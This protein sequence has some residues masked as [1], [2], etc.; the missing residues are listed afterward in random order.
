[1]KEIA[2]SLISIE[3]ATEHKNKLLEYERTSEKRTIVI[4]DEM[5]Y[6][7]LSKENWL[8]NEKRQELKDKIDKL[9]ED[10]FEID[11]RFELDFDSRQVVEV[12]IPKIKDLNEEVKK[13]KEETEFK[14]DYEIVD[15][16]EILANEP[17]VRPY[18]V[19]ENDNKNNKKDN[20]KD[21]KKPKSKSNK[22]QKQSDKNLI[23]YNLPNINL[24]RNRLQNSELFDSTDEG[25]ALSI[26]QP[27]AS[28]VIHSIK[29][30]E[31]NF[32]Y[33]F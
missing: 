31:G 7:D 8:S 29:L 10:K 27:W 13:L 6:F 15:F 19:A 5:D 17:E 30:H 24:V 1:M 16:R 4:D 25:F 21:D 3:S 28:L 22:N 32:I 18:Y 2:S 9:H 33:F 26:N 11:R 23:N 12:N 20:K 14:S